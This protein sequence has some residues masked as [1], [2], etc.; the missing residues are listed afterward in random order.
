VFLFYCFYAVKLPFCFYFLCFYW[1]CFPDIV[2]RNHPTDLCSA[3]RP[4]EMPTAN[5]S[6][7]GNIICS[8]YS[9]YYKSNIKIAIIT[10]F[11]FFEGT[12]IPIWL[13]LSQ[14]ATRTGLLASPRNHNQI[15]KTST[16]NEIFIKK[17]KFQIWCDFVFW[18]REFCFDN[19]FASWIFS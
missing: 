4:K 5:L 9:N 7:A 16:R 13:R 3:L 18:V 8:F 10:L 17:C 14:A 15:I 19:F 1:F 2:W 6:L 12:G 11:S